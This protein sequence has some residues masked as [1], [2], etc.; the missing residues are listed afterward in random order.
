ML[1]P[2]TVPCS[3]WAEV[4]SQAGQSISL[5]H[6][7][8]GADHPGMKSRNR[9]QHSPHDLLDSGRCMTTYI[10]PQPFTPAS[11]SAAMLFSLLLLAQ[12]NSSLRCSLN[13][14]ACEPPSWVSSI[15]LLS[16]RIFTVTAPITIFSY[17]LI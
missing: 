11:L 5:G 10:P 16:P 4:D 14:T 9:P 1:A 6:Q 7:S 17:M 13:G 2:W 15:I 8:H 3:I 12:P